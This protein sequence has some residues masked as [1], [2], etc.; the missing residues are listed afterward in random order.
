MHK[1]FKDER[2]VY[3]SVLSALLQASAFIPPPVTKLIRDTQANEPGTPETTATI[4]HKLASRLLASVDAP[5]HSTADRLFVHLTVL[6]ALGEL[7]A[8]AAL[9][10]TPEGQA[11]AQTSLTVDELRREIVRASGPGALVAEGARAER[12]LVEEK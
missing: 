12:V 8:A 9:L 2:Y 6:R 11:V 5:P 7:R 4:L 1:T 3:W 10:D